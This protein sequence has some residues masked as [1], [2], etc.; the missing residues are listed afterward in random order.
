MGHSLRSRGVSKHFRHRPANGSSRAG[1]GARS[2]S[3]PPPRVGAGLRD[4]GFPGARPGGFGVRERGRRIRPGQWGRGAEGRRAAGVC[5][6]GPDAG[7]AV[8]PPP[9]SGQTRPGGAMASRPARGPP[10]SREAWGGKGPRRVGGGRER[11]FKTLGGC[12]GEVWLL[13]GGQA[14]GHLP[15]HS[16]FFPLE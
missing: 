6:R 3:Q 2:R 4:A 7:E 5:A 9:G 10:A 12:R 11:G 16:V 13:N 15:S 14:A 1:K 8:L